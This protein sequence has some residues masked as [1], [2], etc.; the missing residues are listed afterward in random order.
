ME[1]LRSWLEGMTMEEWGGTAM[2]YYLIVICL[3]AVLFLGVLLYHTYI[4]TRKWI[5]DKSGKNG[6]TGAVLSILLVAVYLYLCSALL[7]GSYLPIILGGWEHVRFLFPYDAL[8]ALYRS[9][10]TYFWF[11]FLRIAVIFGAA[12]ISLIYLLNGLARLLS[13][14]QGRIRGEGSL[15][16]SLVLSMIAVGFYALS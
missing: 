14:G 9:L 10:S 8:L 5:S 7:L 6:N 4:I 13:S 12:V 16:A 3:A 1:R 15:M 2:H 11:P